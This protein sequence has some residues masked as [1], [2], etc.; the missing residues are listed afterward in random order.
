[1]LGHWAG[2][3]CGGRS[4]GSR[5]LLAGSASIPGLG[6]FLIGRVFYADTANTLIAFMGIYVTNEVSFDERATLLGI[7]AS[8]L[9]GLS[10]G[11][12]VDRWGPK[13]TLTVV[14]AVWLV[15]FGLAAAIGGR[16]RRPRLA[17]PVVLAGRPAGW[18]I[19]GR[20][21]GG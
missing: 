16:D 8:V 15:T 18:H 11:V 14:L 5:S 7:G 4:S 1:M 6:R 20:H 9:G 12:V 2:R 3:P 19:P 21:V 17:G 10:W 13:R